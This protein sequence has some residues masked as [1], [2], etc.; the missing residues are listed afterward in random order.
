[1][2]LPV[3]SDAIAAVVLSTIVDVSCREVEDAC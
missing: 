2:G 1:M 3:F